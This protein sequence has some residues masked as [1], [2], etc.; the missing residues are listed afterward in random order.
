MPIEALSI[1]MPWVL[2]ANRIYA[3]PPVKLTIFTTHGT[4]AFEVSNHSDF[5]QPGMTPV[6]T[7]GLATVAG[8]FIRTAASDVTVKLVRD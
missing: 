6:L 8:G 5:A 2:V 4:P 7:N 3:L 1:G